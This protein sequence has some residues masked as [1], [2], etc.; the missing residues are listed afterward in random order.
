MVTTVQMSSEVDDP[1]ANALTGDCPYRR[2]A[3][4]RYR[5]IRG[6]V[7]RTLARQAGLLIAL[8]MALPIVATYPASGPPIAAPVVDAF[9]KVLLVGVLGGATQLVAAA[10]LVA[11]L[12]ARSGSLTRPEANRLVTLEDLATSVSLG[13]GGFAILFSLGYLALGHFEGAVALVTRGE[14]DPFAAVAAAT[15]SG[16]AVDTVAGAALLG[17][18]V[19]WM[20]SRWASDRER[21]SGE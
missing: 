8:A 18:L 11:L 6:P 16:I 10:A 15:G 17:A 21:R 1:I 13:T 4:E 3:V 12:L 20:A 19:C 5:P 14:T 2:A 9:P 7:S